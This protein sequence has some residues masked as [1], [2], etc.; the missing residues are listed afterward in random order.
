MARKTTAKAAAAAEQ[1]KA[2]PAETTTETTDPG[3]LVEV[4]SSEYVPQPI[5]SGEKV[6][7]QL[8]PPEPDALDGLPVTT[9]EPDLI[10]QVNNAFRLA[11]DNFGYKRGYA[12]PAGATMR[13]H[14]PSAYRDELK[15]WVALGTFSLID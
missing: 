4:P 5:D 1:A 12:L 3:K 15:R 14:R 13:I 8:Q 2:N 10:I 11:A 7:T 6:D 9:E